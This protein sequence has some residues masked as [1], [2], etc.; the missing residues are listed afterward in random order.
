MWY[1]PK[2]FIVFVQFLQLVVMHYKTQII[3]FDIPVQIPLMALQCL[4]QNNELSCMSCNYMVWG[5]VVRTTFAP[6]VA[7]N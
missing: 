5:K 3:L 6:N 1:E 7:D 2:P 4:S